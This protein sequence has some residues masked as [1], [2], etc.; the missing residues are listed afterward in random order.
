MRLIDRQQ[1]L[2]LEDAL[3]VPILMTVQEAAQ[4]AGVWYPTIYRWIADGHIRT[5]PLDGGPWMRVIGPSLTAYLEQ[6]SRPRV[7]EPLP[8]RFRSAA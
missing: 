8:W 6:R 4:Y 2:L 5:E 7:P 3:G 1:V